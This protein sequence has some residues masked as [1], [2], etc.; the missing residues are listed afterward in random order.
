MSS[1]L[2]NPTVRTPIASPRKPLPNNNNNN[3]TVSLNT[4]A[5]QPHHTGKPLVPIY[6]YLSKNGLINLNNYKYTSGLAGIIDRVIMTPFWNNVVEYIPL[7]I[8]PNTLTAISLAHAMV[9]TL[10][11]CGYSPTLTEHAPNWV[12]IVATICMFMYQTLDAVDGKQARRTGSSSPL[13][14][15][16]DHVCLCY[17]YCMYV[18][19]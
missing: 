16:F 19:Q 7:T 4:S 5:F 3:N 17:I 10:L 11:I 12:Y 13:G 14:Q 2:T 6:P 1:S 9:A 18:M 15:L 8:A